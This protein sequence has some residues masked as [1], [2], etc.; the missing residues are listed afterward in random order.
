MSGVGVGIT[1]WFHQKQH[2]IFDFGDATIVFEVYFHEWGFII[3]HFFIFSPNRSN[4][5]LQSLII[6]DIDH[7]IFRKRI[8]MFQKLNWCNPIFSE[9]NSFRVDNAGTFSIIN[10]SVMF[11]ESQPTLLICGTPIIQQITEKNR[12]LWNKGFYTDTFNS[13]GGPSEAPWLVYAN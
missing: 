5:L 3:G 12:I 13:C 2:C 9:I 8:M 7:L 11:K 6:F 10:K 1:L 4:E